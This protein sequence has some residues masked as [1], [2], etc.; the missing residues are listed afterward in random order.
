M[1]RLFKALLFFSLLLAAHISWA[2]QDQSALL[3]AA[4][5]EYGKGNYQEA[6]RQ[7]LEAIEHGH[8]NG[9]V[10]YNLGTAYYRLG[11]FGR[12]IAQYRKALELLP[13]DPDVLKNRQ[14]GLISGAFCLFDHL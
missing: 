2:A 3:V 8:V 1:R 6:A 13:N 12:A 14:S 5:A 11:E 7:Y 10:H 9:H 4:G